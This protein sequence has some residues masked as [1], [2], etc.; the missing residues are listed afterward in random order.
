M[1]VDSTATETAAP[2]NETIGPEQVEETDTV[3]IGGGPAGL[4]TSACLRRAG[5]PFV[6]LERSDRVGAAW[7]QRYDRL[8]LHTAKQHSAL[9]Y[10]RFPKDCPRFPSRLQVIE[11]LEGYARRF[12]LRA[13]FGEEV[14]SVRREGNRWETEQ[15]T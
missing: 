15:R 2:M 12:E 11:Y 13:R 10:M 1:E 5:V 14:T 6:M 7:H 3:I 4:A 8:H 9:P